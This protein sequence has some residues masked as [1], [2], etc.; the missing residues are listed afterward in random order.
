MRSLLMEKVLQGIV[1]FIM[2]KV[3]QGIVTFIIEKVLQGIVTFIIEC[4]DDVQ[5]IRLGSSPFVE[6]F[7]WIEIVETIAIYLFDS[8]CV[9]GVVWFIS[10]CVAH[11]L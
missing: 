5:I 3:L 7:C 1:T 9:V 6:D 11:V 4:R 2:E 10:L 8:C